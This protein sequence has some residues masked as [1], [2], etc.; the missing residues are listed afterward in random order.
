MGGLPLPTVLGQ[1]GIGMGVH[2]GM[3][4][5]PVGGAEQGRPARAGPGQAGA[6]AAPVAPPAVDRGGIVPEERGDVSH[7][8]TAIHCGQGSFSDIVGG[9]RALHPPS[10]PPWHNYPQP[11]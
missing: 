9:V 1:R 11:L 8:V 3:Q 10:V 5:R 6:G 7:T 4:H 2:L